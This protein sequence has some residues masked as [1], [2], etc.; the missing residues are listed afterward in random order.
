MP[1]KYILMASISPFID[2]E[3]IEANGKQTIMVFLGF[4]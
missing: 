1:S 3:W 4:R 2:W